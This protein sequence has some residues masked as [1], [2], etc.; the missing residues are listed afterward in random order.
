M[1]DLPTKIDSPSP[2]QASLA[3]IG[4]LP[5]GVKWRILVGGQEAKI[6]NVE[7][8]QGE[9]PAETLIFTF[10]APGYGHEVITDLRIMDS[11]DPAAPNLNDVEL[12]MMTAARRPH[13]YLDHDPTKN[14]RRR[15][16]GR[17]NRRR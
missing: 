13:S 17:L 5:E 1:T 16:A 10:E 15:R 4:D 12:T 14:V 9:G 6:I 2:Q 7:R 3:T 8:R 11:H